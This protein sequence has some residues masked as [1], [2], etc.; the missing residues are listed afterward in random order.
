M[1]WIGVA[2][3]AA[4]T[5]SVASEALSPERRVKELKIILPSPPSPVGAYK[6]TIRHGGLLF[7]SG[8]MPIEDGRM[9][10]TGKLGRDLT[11]AQGYQAA[12]MSALNVLAQIRAAIGSLDRVER[13][14]RVDGYI[15]S[16]PEWTNHGAVLNGASELL[17][18]VF[19]E[20]A[21]HARTAFGQSSLPLDAAVE[22]AVIVA[23]TE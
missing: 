22:L 15:N 4:P 1:L 14:I 8:Q 16:T 12:R 2:T 18:E 3:A 11:D 20:R 21:G 17:A 23:V 10:F 13:I 6:A 19:G 9:V 5:P 7:I